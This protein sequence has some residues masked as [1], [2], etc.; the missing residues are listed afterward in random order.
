M[1]RFLKAQDL[2]EMLDVSESK[3][4]QIVRMLNEELAAQGYITVRGRVPSA[5]AAERLCLNE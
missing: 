3:A 2:A 5:Y 1:K 4:Y